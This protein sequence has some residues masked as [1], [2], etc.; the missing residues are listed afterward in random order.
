MHALKL[1]ALIAGALLALS[2]EAYSLDWNVN[3][4]GGWVKVDD[5]T[6]PDVPSPISDSVSLPSSCITWWETGGGTVS[7]QTS[8]GPTTAIADG[9]ANHYAPSLL[10]SYNGQVDVAGYEADNCESWIYSG[11][12]CPCVS[13]EGR[14]ATDDS[15]H[16]VTGSVFKVDS[17]LFVKSRLQCTQANKI[18]ADVEQ[19]VEIDQQA[20]GLTFSV[21][22]PLAPNLSTSITIFV[23]FSLAVSLDVVG[24]SDDHLTDPT[25]QDSAT[26]K[27]DGE[28]NA[29]ADVHYIG[30]K[31]LAATGS[32]SSRLR[33]TTAVTALL[34]EQPPNEEGECACSAP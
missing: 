29:D 14:A 34:L 3:D 1:A 12:L 10:C 25:F 32:M 11:T 19:R 33:S 8:G 17:N 20:G 26:L 2:A 15:V 7:V 24:I 18:T 5:P 9:D 13:Y 27:W 23:G 6:C 16:T 28:H 4:E 30:R 21:G 31:V 22:L